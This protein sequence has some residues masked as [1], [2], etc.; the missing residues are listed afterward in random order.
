[1]TA[2]TAP[3]TIATETRPSVAP[4][5]RTGAVAG[6]V[7]AGATTA[8]AAVASA[9]DVGLEVDGEAIPAFG[10]GQVT[11]F[12]VLIGLVLATVLARRARHP[13]TTFTRVTVVLTA[14]SCIPSILSGDGTATQ[15]TLVLTHLV[16]AAIVIPTVR[17][18]LPR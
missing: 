8:I 9:L 18:R 2:T 10:F 13:Q 12:F 4:I 15:L 7:A 1:M 6:L 16:A 17:Q 5:W 14:V 3:T 11:V